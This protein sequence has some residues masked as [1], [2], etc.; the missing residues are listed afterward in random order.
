MPK[1][2]SNILK[3]VLI[4]RNFNIILQVLRV[5]RGEQENQGFQAGLD[6]QEKLEQKGEQD[7]LLCIQ[8]D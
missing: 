4:F 5:N 8:K 1:V 7:F 6:L 2:R 3:F